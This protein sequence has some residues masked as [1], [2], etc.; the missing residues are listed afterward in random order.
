MRSRFVPDPVVLA[1]LPLLAADSTKGGGL[2]T[3]GLFLTSRDLDGAPDGALARAAYDLRARTRTTPNGVWA[4]TTTARLA[5]GEPVLLLGEEHRCAT[6]PS[7]AWLAAAADRALDLP[8]VHD[9]LRLF[10]NPAALRRG[11]VLEA[12]HPGPDGTAQ[13]GTVRVTEV[14]TWLL[15]ECGR[16]GGAAAGRVVSAALERW[17]GADAAAVR[18]A[19]TALVR[20]GL[21][22]TDLLP[23]DLIDDPLGHL[24]TKLPS[25]A[26]LCA[27]VLGL[28]ALLADAD[29]YRPGAPERLPLLAAARRA[30]D[31][32]HTTDR[33]LTCDTVADGELRL[34]ATVGRAAAGT[35]DVLWRIGHRTVPLQ[36]WTAKFQETYGPHRMVPLLEAVDPATGI[37]SPGPQDAIGARTD[38]DDRRTQ[39]LLELL[40][41]AIARGEQEVELTEEMVNALAHRG[42]GRP[43]RTAEVHVRVREDDGGRLALAI[44]THASQDA[45][46]AAGRLA[47]YLS[48]LAP[49]PQD[50]GE[51]L[52]VEIVCRPLTA[53]TGALA[54]ESGYTAY[55][56]PV[57]LPLTG[58]RDLDPRALLVTVT[59]AGH[60]ALYSPQLGRL[61]RP[62]LLS[63]ITRA[64][65]PPAAQ[66]LHLLGHADERPW[67]PWSWGPAA[68]APYTPRVTYRST[69]LAPQ[70]WL[71][72]QGLHALVD[73]RDRWHGCL[74]D[75]LARPTMPVPRQVVIEE[76]DRHLPIDLR[77]A[78][79]RE[80]LRRSVRRGCRTVS[81]VLSGRPPVHGRDG[82]HHLELVIGLR[83]QHEAELPEL[84]DPRTVA[85]A[86][87]ADTTPHGGTWLSLAVPAP[88]RH[89]DAILAQ[90][91]H[92]PNMLSYWL[93]YTTPG[94]GP[95][96]RL[97]YHGTPDLLA[98]VQQE[99]AGLSARLAEQ[100]LTNGHLAAAPY[101]RETQRYGGP[102]AIAAA[103]AVF[104]AD[105]ALVR[106]AL[107]EL[108]DDQRIVLAAH[109]AAAI[110][111]T[112]NAPTA[113]RPQPLPGNLRRR[114]ETLRARC[115]T[116]TVPGDL[117]H[118]W[119]TLLDAVTAYRPLLAENV[120]PLCA[121]DL[122]HLH[123]NRLLGTDRGREHLARSLATDLLRHA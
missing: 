100:H 101:Q 76:S 48:D 87:A 94:L 38:L 27:A 95:H 66:L 12:E 108:D 32:I 119:K 88:V 45:G 99:L 123:C 106:T 24:A 121:S 37:G 20:T 47:R 70:R 120:A 64:L 28:R 23:A 53:S 118:S 34:P 6:L 89:Q 39:L 105:S 17:P 33:P 72:P 84:L 26:G 50:G 97:R 5:P 73:H 109:T 85:R 35:V 107:Q 14:S 22:L 96:L 80:L 57:G 65:L 91:P 83:R 103:E 7:P 59:R 92:Y 116:V 3:E 115:R 49:E 102:G 8:D 62:L 81:E 41:A 58:S 36:A 63:R 90:L 44:G 111:R 61:V 60:L 52:P 42:D 46:S 1:R 82:R 117:A 56:I 54:V 2:V 113:A 30:A 67:H 55:R 71:L 9:R 78:G 114:R 110:A 16:T 13:L 74:D 11:G 86:R 43:P 104:A 122:I 19:I 40:T 10:A 69:V 4:A 79:H 29:R 112:L 31:A 21:L 98:A 68:L 93:R 75:W 15:S 51:P 18:A 77:E 25:A